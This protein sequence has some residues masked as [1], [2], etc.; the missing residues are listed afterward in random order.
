MDDQGEDIATDIIGAKN[1]LGRRLRIKRPC[2][3]PR[4]RKV[5]KKR[6]NQA[7]ECQADDQN[8]TNRQFPVAEPITQIKPNLGCTLAG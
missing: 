8:Q 5:H 2:R 7:E 3:N 4:T 6:A 1:I